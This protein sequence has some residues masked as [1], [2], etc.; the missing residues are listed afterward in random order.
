[1]HRLGDLLAAAR[2]AR[3]PIERVPRQRLEAL[4]AQRHQG[5][6]AIAAP[7][8]YV[9]VDEILARAAGRSA[10]VLMLDGIEDPQNLGSM[11][12]SAD[13]AGV[14]GIV[15]GARRAVAVTDV[16]ARAAA[17]AT[18]HMPIARVSSMAQTV[19]RMKEGGLWVAVADPN[20]GA[21]PWT[22]DLSGPIALVV[23]S[24]GKGVSDLV[25]K[26]ADMCTSLPMGGHVASLNAAVAAA[27]LMFEVRRQ[28]LSAWRP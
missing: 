18:E 23:G 13:A 5:V 24:E 9:D 25:R 19:E 2:A 16:V 1:M 12:R 26:R 21:A 15:I 17:G 6:V 8:R 4:T 22:L 7:M 10:F 11:V 20:G 3:V 27:V 14:D 28:R